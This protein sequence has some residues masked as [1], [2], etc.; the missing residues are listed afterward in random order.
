MEEGKIEIKTQQAMQKI[1]QVIKPSLFVEVAQIGYTDLMAKIQ[2]ARNRGSFRVFTEKDTVKLN[3]AI[4]KIGAKIQKIQ[5][6]YLA[7][8]YGAENSLTKDQLQIL[9][10]YFQLT[11]FYK[12]KLNKTAEWFHKRIRPFSRE[13]KN[14]YFK[15]EEILTI[16]LAIKEAAG[17]LLSIQMI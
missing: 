10:D 11:Y 2:G 15:E 14:Y 7:P 12:T 3:K 6:D 1:T 9:K 13:M 8:K 16:N 4:V 5:I 17:M